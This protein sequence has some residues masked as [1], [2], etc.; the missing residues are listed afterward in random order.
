[1]PKGVYKHHPNQLFQEGHIGFWVG[2]KRPK[3][4]KI[5][6]AFK[7]IGNKNALGNFRSEEIREK[8]SEIK[9]GTE[10]T[11]SVDYSLLDDTDKEWGRKRTTIKNFTTLQKDKLSAVLNLVGSKLK[12]EEQL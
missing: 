2:K 12:S 4:T 8:D 7:K 5:K 3:K 9:Q 6:M 10:Y 11:I 1:M